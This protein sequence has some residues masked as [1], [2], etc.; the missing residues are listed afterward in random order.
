MKK[1]TILFMGILLGSILVS[2]YL[3]PHSALLPDEDTV[4]LEQTVSEL[5]V[6]P[7]PSD[8]RFN[9]SFDYNGKEKLSAKVFDITGKQ[10]KNISEDLVTGETTVTATVDLESPSSGIY[11]LR[12]ELDSK[13]LTKKIIVR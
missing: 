5:K 4:R 13:T 9:L 2:P 6:Y 8:G 3:F 12:I 1:S 10:V 7:N 11:F